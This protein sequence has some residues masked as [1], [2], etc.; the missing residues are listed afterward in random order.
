MSFKKFIVAFFIIMS[1]A[2]F[3]GCSEQ[4]TMDNVFEKDSFGATVEES[5]NSSILVKV[6]NDEFDIAYDY[7]KVSLDLK[8]EGSL[9]EFSEDDKVRVYYDGVI[10][11]G[12]PAQINNAYTIMLSSSK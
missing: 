11:D 9:K 10:K 3:T 1:S 8:V 4:V 5:F 7:I 12:H 2:L 6:N